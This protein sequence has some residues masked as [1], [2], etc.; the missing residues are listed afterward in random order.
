MLSEITLLYVEDDTDIAEEIA[1]F[2]QKHVKKLYVAQDGQEGL[3]V[4]QQYRPDAVVTDIQMPRLN[5][6]D[7]SQKIREIDSDVPIV[8]TSA[9]NDTDFLT[10]S[11]E[12]GVS[13]YVIKPVNL[14]KMLL[15][16]E[17]V[18]EPIRLKHELQQRNEELQKVNENLDKLVAEKTKD[19]EFLYLHDGLTSLHNSVALQKALDEENFEYF[20]LLDIAQFTYIN[21]QYGKEFGDQVLISVAEL[22]KIHCNHHIY[23][24]KIE[25]DKFVFLLRNMGVK[26][27]EEFAQQIHAF[28]D[29]RKIELD[30]IPLG[31]SFHIGIAPVNDSPDVMIHAEYA[32]DIT[33]KL[34]ARIYSF[35]NEKNEFIQKNK[36]M[37]EWMTITK[38]MVEHERIVPYF[39]PIFDRKS[40][41][42]EK[43]EVLARGL[44]EGKVVS[45]YFF[46]EPAEQL[47]L[48][49]SIT[50]MMIQKS[51]KYFKEYDYEF[52]INI[53]ERDLY[54]NYLF[55]YLKIKSQ[56]HGIDPS[57]VTLE[58]LETITA[59]L[60]HDTLLHQINQL[61]SEGYKISIDDFGT[62][63]ANFSRLMTMNFDY[64]KLD[65]T[66]INGIEHN[67]KKQLM[68]QSIVEL[69]KVLGVKTIAE[70]IENE[71][72]FSA[73]EECGVDMM[74]G[75]YIGKPNDTTKI[76]N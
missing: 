71:T 21:K 24:Y 58:I 51:F 48:I 11:I 53:S 56:E 38:E 22:L 2:L 16:L 40:K 1:Y 75:Y 52:S 50:K 49:S 31:I 7:M 60:D 66:F 25:S 35:Y 17:K 9:Y 73:V 14:K 3:E 15:I 55:N 26:K 32:L 39:Q 65:G 43:F 67:R 70:Y 33:K 19:L 41:K 69:A 47:G 37:V 18:L 12:L 76:S 20:M 46:I 13:G 23:L 61:K 72:V 54:E 57:R 64:I 10:R 4:F 6:L 62:A 27:V 44:H 5:G 63:N 29:A 45:P 28:F 8:I 36:D 34:G 59:G 30:L 42:I 74:Q 68:V